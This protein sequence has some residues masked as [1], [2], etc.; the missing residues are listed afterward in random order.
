MPEHSHMAR[1]ALGRSLRKAEPGNL[2]GRGNREV[3]GRSCFLT[4]IQGTS[5]GRSTWRTKS[6]WRRMWRGRA[7]RQVEPRKQERRCYP[8]CCA[9][10]V[11][12]GNSRLP[13]VAMAGVSRDMFVGAIEVIAVRARV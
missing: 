5:V 11:V 2:L 12:G 1:P 13:T 7:V 10:V 9:A 8:V 4:T 6:G 3:N